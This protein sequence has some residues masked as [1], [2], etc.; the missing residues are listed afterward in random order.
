[1]ANSLFFDVFFS[2]SKEIY[3]HFVE[4][5]S[6]E[7]GAT[8]ETENDSGDSQKGMDILSNDILKERF[9]EKADELDLYGIMS[10]EDKEII[11][12]NPA[13]S[14]VVAF[15]PLDGSTN[16]ASNLSCGSI[17]GVYK[18][19]RDGNVLFTG[20]DI[21]LAG[22]SLYSQALQIVW[23]NGDDVKMYQ[24]DKNGELAHPL[25]LKNHSVSKQKFGCVSGDCLVDDF[26]PFWLLCRLRFKDNDRME[27]YKN[28]WSGCMVADV[29]RIV[30]SGGFFCYP[31]TVKTPNGKLRIWY[32]CLPMGMVIKA[33]GGHTTYGNDRIGYLQ[34]GDFKLTDNYHLKFPVLLVRN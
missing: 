33:M 23:T 25:D 3:S 8:Q 31:G 7:L 21:V 1:M 19:N 22:Y 26:D 12:I 29:H 32:E 9:A 4:V 5:A 17:L 6:Y 16:I 14:Y 28:R 27:N 13:G 15:D 34:E 18:V 2:A 10:E 24:V 20:D 30:L 11:V